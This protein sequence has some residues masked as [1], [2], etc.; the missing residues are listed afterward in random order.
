MFRSTVHGR[1]LMGIG[2]GGDLEYC[3]QIDITDIVPIYRD[4]RVELPP[5]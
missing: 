3:A 2:L 1:Y 5:R 4:G